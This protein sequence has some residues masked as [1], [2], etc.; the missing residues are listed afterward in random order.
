VLTAKGLHARQRICVLTAK[1]CVHQAE[2][3]RRLVA[4]DPAAD[5][6]LDKI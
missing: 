6:S 2:V 3:G 1:G 4:A 5:S